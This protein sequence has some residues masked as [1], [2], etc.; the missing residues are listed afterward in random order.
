MGGITDYGNP[1]TFGYRMRAA[2]VRPLLEMIEAVHAQRG[3]VR[4]IDVGGTE[5]Y[6]SIISAG[7][8]DRHGV[9]IAVVNLPE[10]PMP[11]DHGRFEF[12]AGD[13]CHLEVFDDCSFDIAHS[14]SVIEHV[15]DSEHM[16]DFAR[17]ITRVA[18]AYF[19]QTPNYWFPV[20]PHF[21]TMFFHWLPKWM[22]VWLLLRLNL[23][24]WGRKTNKEA[25]LRA[26]ESAHLL[27]RK[28]MQ[29]LFKEADIIT[30]RFLGLPKSLI[31]VKQW[32]GTEQA[33]PEDDCSTP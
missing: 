14:N 1:G 3:Q 27:D 2:R 5:Q 7:F 8:L 31:A 17:E 33:N 11:D 19:V 4:I 15:G 25:A 9:T 30:E 28:T 12:I 6:W 10:T 24:E 22:R 32:F 18:P 13:G 29:T 20:E 21:K 23:G 26:V 16:A